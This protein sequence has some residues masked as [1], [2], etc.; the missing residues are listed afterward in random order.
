MPKFIIA[1]KDAT[2][3]VDPE[4]FEAPDLAAAVA[5]LRQGARDLWADGIRIGLNRAHWFMELWDLEGNVLA[6]IRISDT[7][8]DVDICEPDKVWP[9]PVDK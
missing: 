7:A 8:R 6:S 9:R 4:P 2:E 1:V 3:V 5:E